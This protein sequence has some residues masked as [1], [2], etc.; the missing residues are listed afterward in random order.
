MTM[1]LERRLAKLEATSLPKPPKV[2]RRLAEPQ[3]G[4]TNEEREQ[5]GRDLAQARAECDFI[6]ILT[7]LKPLPPDDGKLIYAKDETTAQFRMAA[8]MPSKRGNDSLLHDALED[9]HKKG[10]VLQAV[11]Q[12]AS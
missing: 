10:R 2:V 1:N 9:A 5:Y 7:A 6:I 11:K 4:A 3:E 12:P 8:H